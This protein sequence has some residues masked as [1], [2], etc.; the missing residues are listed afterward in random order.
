MLTIICITALAYFI[1]GKDFNP[2]LEK[3]KNTDWRAETDKL[4]KKL[5]PYAIKVGRA[6]ATPLAM[7]VI[8]LTYWF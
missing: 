6:A 1:M 8:I 4:L 2:L 3:I 7:T 5:R